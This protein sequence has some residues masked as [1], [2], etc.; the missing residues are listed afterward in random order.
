METQIRITFQPTGRTAFVLRGTT[1]LE[2]AARVGLV[3][4]TPCGAIR[5]SI[6]LLLR[7]AGLEV[8]SLKTV[9]IAGGFGN[10]IR[11]SS[12]QRIGLLPGGIDHQRIRYVGNVSLA[13][14]RAARLSTEARKLGEEMAR[15]VKHV[16]LSTMEGFQEAFAEAMLFPGNRAPS[17]RR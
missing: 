11:R 15:R 7:L 5:A 16:E 13:G 6:A 17:S 2:A 3:L 4:E 9:L 14:A 12:A 8:S 1:I 10:V